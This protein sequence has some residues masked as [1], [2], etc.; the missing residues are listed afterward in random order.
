MTDDIPVSIKRLFFSLKAEIIAN[1]VILDVMLRK[2]G[3]IAPDLQRAIAGTMALMADNF[4][5]NKA[6]LNEAGSDVDLPEGAYLDGIEVQIARWRAFAAAADQDEP[7]P[8]NVFSLMV[9]GKD[10]SRSDT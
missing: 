9:G 7:P 5:R 4:E 3:D 10:D 8:A 2:M 1:Q 6:T